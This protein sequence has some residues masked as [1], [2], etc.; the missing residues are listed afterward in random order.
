MGMFFNKKDNDSKQRFGI[1][2]LTIGA[3]SVLL[4]TLI[5]GIGTQEQNSKAQAATTETSNTASSTDLVDNHQ[6]KNTYLSSS[7]VNETATKVN[8]KETSAGNEQQDSQSAVAQDKQSGEKVADVVTNNRS[9]VE[10]K[11]SNNAESSEITD[12]TKNT[13]NSDRAEVTNKEANT[14]TDSKKVTQKTSG[15]AVND[16]NKNVAETTT[17]T[18]N[19]KVSSYTSNLDLENIQESLE[20]QAKENNG[21]A[22][23]AKSVTSLLRSSDAANFQVLAALTENIAEA[24]KIKANAAVTIPSTDG[25][26]TLY[27]SRNTW[28]NTTDGNQPTKVLLSGN[29][30]SGDTVTISIPSYGIVGVNSPT[31]DANYGSASLKDMGNDKVVIYNFTTSGVINP[32]VTI[33][34]DNGYG[35]KPTPM[36]ITQP[37]VKDITWTINGV[38]QTSAE[39]HID[40]NPVWNPKFSLSKPN[41]NSTDQN[42]LKKMIPNYE[43]IYQLAINETNGV[44]PGQDYQNSLPYPSSKINSAVNYG[45]VITIPMPKGYVLD[46]SATM[47]L[48]NFGD[49]TTITQDGN[50]IIITVPKGSGTQNWNSGGPYQLVGSYNIP[51]P[52]TATTYTADAPITIVQKL[53]NDGSQTKTWTGPTVSQDFYGANDQIPLGQM[54]LYAKAAYNGNQLLNNGHKQI[55]AYFGITNES[56]ASYNDYSSN[57]TFNFDE[58]LGVTELKT[59]TI[60]GTSNYKYTIT[61]ADGTTSEGQ[62]NAGN[63]ITGT[64]VITNIVVSPDNF[65]RDQSTAVD[66]PTNKFA[67]QTTQSVN[68]FEAYGAVPETVKSGTQLVANLTFTG[69]IQQGNITKYLT[70]KIQVDQTVVSSA[71]LTSSSGIFGYQSNTATGQSNVGYLS[72]YAGGGKTNNIYEPIFYYVLPEWF[73]VYDFSTDYTK[74]PDFVPNTNNGVIG[75]PKLSVFTVPTEISG[76]SRQVV[77][78]DY[79]GTGYNFLAGQGANNQIHLNTL[80]DGTNGTYQGIIYIVSPTTKLTNTAYNPNNTSNFAPSGITFNPDWVQGNTSN[81]YYVGA[82]GFTI[83]QV[84]GANTASVAQGNQNDILVDSGVS[85]LYGSNEMEYAVRLINGSGTKLTNVVAMVNLPQASDTSF[86]FQLNGRPVYNGDKTG[87]TFLYSTE[88]GNLK[89]NND[90]DGTKPDETGY[91]PADQ[92][93]DWS[94]IKS[95]IIK[96]SSLSNNDR[97][98]RLIFTGIDPNLVNDAGKTG[99]ISTGFYSDT[100]KPFISSL[101][102]Y[103]S[104]TVANKVKPANITITGEANINF[105]LQ[106]TDEN[107]QLQTINL[108]DLSTSYNLAQNNT[109]LTEQEAIELANKNAASSIPANYEI[110]SATLQSG[111]KTWQTDAPEGT[112]VFGG[113]VQYFYNNA[114]VLLQ[115]VPIQR[116]LTYQVIDENDPSNP[117]TIQPNTDLLNNGQVITG[118]QGSNVPNDATTAYDAVKNALEA[119]GYVI[120]S[121]SSTV[122]TIFGPDNTALT[123][124]VTHKTINVS[125]PDQW[126]STSTDADK[127]SLSKTITRTITVEGL[128]TAV[129]GTTQTVTFTRTAVVDE[130]TGK[131]IGYVDPSD[132]SQ[133]IT[134]GD[135]AWTSV[136]NTWSAFTPKNIPVGYS[137]KS[138]T[139]A[140]GNYANVTSTDGKLTGVA[141]TTVAPNESDVTVTITYQGNQVSNTIT[142]IDT[143]D[144]NKQVGET[145]TISGRVGE[146]DNNLN[147]TVPEGYELANGASLPTSYTFEATNTPITIPLVHKH[148]T[149]GPND[150]WPSTSTN[151]DK[152][153]LSETITRTITV[154]G[155][156]TNVPSVEQNVNFTRRAIVDEVTGKVIGYVD[157]SDSTET[158]TNGNAAWTSDNPTWSSWT[159]S[160]VPEGYYIESAKVGNTDYPTVTTNANGIITGLNSV[161]VTPKMSSITVNVVYN[162]VNLDLTI[163]HDTI[164]NTYNGSE[165]PVSPDIISEITHTVVSSNNNVP[166]QNIA[167]AIQDANLTSDDYSYTDSQGNVLTGTPTNAGNY[168]IILNQNGLDKLNKVAGGLTI[169]YDPSKSYVNYTIEK[170][171]ASAELEGNNSKQ[172]DGQSVTNV[173]VTKDGNIK[174]TTNV[175]GTTQSAYQ[176]QAGDYD[177]YSADGSTRLSSAPTNVGNYMIKLNS[178]GIANIKAHYGNSDNI[179]WT[180]D[181]ITGS[182]TYEITK[183]AATISLTPDENKQT[184]SWTG[185]EISINPADFVPTITTDNGVTLTVPAGTLAVGDYT[186]THSPVAPGTY[187]VSLTD[188]GIEKIKKAISTSENYVWNNTGNGVLE[189]VNAKANY[190]MSGSGETTYTG[191]AVELPMDQLKDA[192]S[193][194]NT[195]SG[196]DLVI[197]ELDVNDFTWSSDTAP[198]NVGNYTIKLSETGINKIAAANPNYALTLGMNAFTYKIN[199]AKASATVSGENS[200]TYNGKAISIN[201]IYNG[202]TISVKITGLDDQEFTYT[203]QT[204]DYTWNVSDPTNVGTY[205]LTLNSTGIGHLQDLLNDKYG[206]GNVTIANSQVTGSAKYTIEKA[207][208]SVTLSGNQDETYTAEEFTN[209]NIK[210]SDYKVTLSN[211]LEYKLVD[212]DLEFI[213]NQNPTNVG[214]YTVQLSDQGKKNIAAVQGKNYE[215]S[216]NDTGVGSF[217][218]TKATP[219]AS[220]TGQGEKTYDGTPISGYVPKVTI[221]APGKNDVTLVAGTD[222]VWTK[223]GQTF[224]TAPSDAGNYTVSLTSDG[225]GKI[226]A[227]NAANL[228]WSNVIISENARYTITKAQAT[229]NFAQPASQ[230]VEYG[231][232]DFDVN[233]FKPSISTNN[234]VTVNVPEGVSLSA[235]AGDFEFTNA[236]GN[237]TT[238]VPTGLGTYTVTLSEAGFK[239]LQSQTNNYDWVNNAKGTYIVTKAT[240]VSVTL[241]GNQEVIYTGNTFTNSDINVNDYQVTLE[242]G[243]T[244][245]LVAGDLE[246]GPSQDPTNAGAYKVQLSAQGKENIAKVDS[247][248]YSYNFDNAGTGNFEIKKATPSIEFKAN[249]EKIFDGTSIALGDYKTQPSVTVTAPGNPTITLETGDYVWIKDGVTYTTAPSNVGSYTIQLS[250]SGKN[251]ILQNS[252]NTENLDWANAKI[253]GQGSY[254]ITEANATANLSGN[255][256]KTYDG[257]PVTTTE[258]NSKDGTVEVTIT[259]PNSSETVTYKLQD[260]DY[261]WNTLNGDAPTDAGDYTFKLS[262]EA[263]TNLQSAIDGKWGKGNVKI[264]DADLKGEATFTINKDNIKITGNGSQI[265]TYTGSPQVVDPNN[266]PVVLT[267]E[268]TGPVPTIPD[269]TLTSEDFVVKGKDGSPVD[270]TNVGDYTVYL[271]P[272][273]VDKLKKLNPNYNWPTTEQEVGKLVIEA[274]QA[275]ATVSGENSR[276]YNGQVISTVD[277]YQ[278]G[279]INVTIYGING[280]KITY[281]LKDGDYNW[282]VMDPTN[283]GTYTLTLNDTGISHL[284]EVLTAKY[285]A[286]N[287][288]LA[289]SA[290]TGNAKFTITPAIIK[291]SGNGSQTGTYTGSPQVVDP[292][293]FPIRL[294]PEG[295]APSPTIPDGTLT[296][297]D[298]VVKNKD[299]KPVNP[300]NVGDY[301]VY[302]TPEG[303]DKLKKLNPNYNWPTTEQEVGALTITPA[304]MDVTLSGND[305]KVSDGQPAKVDISTLVDNLT[306]NN[307]NKNGLTLADFSWNTSDGSA[308]I[309]VGNY[310]IT[311]NENG[312]KK[313]QIN[314]SN[315]TVN[316]TGEFK[317]TII[318]ASQKIEYVDGNGNIIKVI[319]NIGTDASNYGEKVDFDVKQNVPENYKLVNSNVP[320]QVTIE[321]GVTRFVIEPNIVTTTDTKTVT[322]TIIVEAPDGSE[323]KVDQTVTFTRPQY[324]D[325]VNGEVTYGAWDKSSGNWSKYTAPEIPGYTSNEVPEEEVTPDTEDKTVTV[326]YTK[327]P[328]VETTDTKTVTRTII[329]ETPDGSESKVV[330]TVTFTRPQ[331]TDPVNGEVTYGDWDKSSGSWDKYTA[332]EIPGYTSNEVPEEEVTPDTEDQTIR[333]GYSKQQEPETPTIPSQPADNKESGKVSA[334]KQQVSTTKI[335]ETNIVNTVQKKVGKQASRNR[336]QVNKKNDHTLP[337]TGAHKD[338]LAI[339]SGALAVGIGLLGLSLD[340]KKKK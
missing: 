84:G 154:S 15:Q 53:N 82:N 40:V 146:T 197:P 79:S 22:L 81:L 228:D 114:T 155:L 59:P 245:K 30:L 141:Q 129:E 52:N 1:R 42:A 271:T 34:A 103:N 202:G 55:V 2:K 339:I 338:M 11:S 45:T 91:V 184:S 58:G 217:N 125:T 127:V 173:E 283:I 187:Q 258:I 37:T 329:V 200:R 196:Q 301:T 134:D 242:N 179:N 268:G 244:Y 13:V 226:K 252:N 193:S 240:D 284:Q 122:P 266:F 165:Q 243:Q 64:G 216:F 169:N 297:D 66:L 68:A 142:F 12:N 340:R 150:T 78:I 190:Q 83:N 76:L 274:A 139:D 106:Y 128:P 295:D 259:I 75:T 296:S 31:I 123:I 61:Y 239:K 178:T 109:M 120:S 261:T 293:N 172:Y 327:N 80:P 112:P 95:I 256:S 111:G 77:K 181:A 92:V 253:S 153:P 219:S 65:E 292:N 229:V 233:N 210:V 60:P 316:V 101:A 186:V 305:S 29:V 325:P 16:V 323:N 224:T 51:M 163:N 306:S 48:N 170:A 188:S 236:S 182:A 168:R 62:V 309:E 265:G 270:P 23:D 177:W 162:K 326:K 201:D 140:N 291:I 90:P 221:T 174:V 205:T 185:N 147:L 234:H 43:S 299:G 204:G 287:V 39:F 337:Q 94:K 218:I 335:S 137:I 115:A 241:I 87:Y 20:Q 183:A 307:L 269:G 9:T 199:A 209:S 41:P 28:G 152:V 220:F 175:P 33:P 56:I 189:I 320:T 275:S 132:T 278:G 288:T 277:L 212:G 135:N 313:L 24:D 317:Y 10:D 195:V 99:Y 251:K 254:I 49:K 6:N 118:N 47:Q 18:K 264:T 273:G 214:T 225:I 311:L 72:V 157:P 298:F 159:N 282:N 336:A 25:R 69:T 192:I 285:G 211:G 310:T 107:G 130:V 50:N 96:T 17:D 19:T 332:P 124:Y 160:T 63:T 85:D 119:K 250:E 21:K 279:N 8:E 247:T 4:S 54:P 222:Y 166:I 302:L 97:S 138:I 280:N 32:I 133:T 46:E 272:E 171:E 89:S 14:Q 27:I 198:T 267:T 144:N 161:D 321:N 260:G 315:Y 257:N 100:T 330:Q 149:V 231:K 230:T 227:V 117:V 334:V 232:N 324:T 131:V 249:A 36:Q 319:D 73:S 113:Q 281:T 238:T 180:E 262:P 143:D 35:A 286:G 44:A 158:I 88:L 207:N 7:E 237:T 303:V 304:K 176:L 136:N 235:Q 246:F 248:H 3:C 255:S 333:I 110:K 314:N 71:D 308:P 206:N 322:R 102:V 26:Y 5:L 203:L 98:D 126:P 67:N 108:P 148:K 70:S 294:T 289:N 194:S 300:T 276:V 86:A 93:T 215:Y 164:I 104:S 223:D 121:K 290:V 116:T 213:P 57:L 38:E 74:L 328:L 156:P 263:L 191:S 312:L 105:K 331:Y 208:V 167:Q 145:I 151:A 318:A